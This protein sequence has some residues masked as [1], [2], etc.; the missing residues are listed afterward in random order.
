MQFRISSTYELTIEADS[1]SEAS[2]Q[3]GLLEADQIVS[4][5]YCTAIDVDDVEVKSV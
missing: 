4:S 3:A 2:E 5:G 1:L